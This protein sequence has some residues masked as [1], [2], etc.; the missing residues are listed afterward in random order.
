MCACMYI[1]VYVVFLIK[2][3]VCNCIYFLNSAYRLFRKIKRANAR[4]LLKQKF[5]RFDIY[6]VKIL[7][8][9]QIQNV[10]PKENLCVVAVKIVRLYRRIPKYDF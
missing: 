4:L 8:Y 5:R 1:I 9:H 10:L 6:C 7:Y 2:Y 3:V